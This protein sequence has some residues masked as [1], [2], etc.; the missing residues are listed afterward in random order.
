MNVSLDFTIFMMLIVYHKSGGFA[1]E[2]IKMS[3]CPHDDKFVFPL[4][5]RT[6]FDTIKNLSIIILFDKLKFISASSV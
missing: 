5:H 1:R 3:V 2:D 4:S 6:A